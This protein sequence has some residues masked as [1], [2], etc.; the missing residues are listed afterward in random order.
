VG[1]K[2]GW[3]GKGGGE[4]TGRKGREGKWKG[5]RRDG[6]PNKKLVTGLVMW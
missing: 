1:G 4:K 3:E 2:R 5:R 6:T